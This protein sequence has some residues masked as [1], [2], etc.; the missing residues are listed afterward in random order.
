MGFVRKNTGI[1]LTGGGQEDAAREA[2]RI[3]TGKGEEAIA[4]IDEQIGPFRDFG[5]TAGNQLGGAVLGQDALQGG[6]PFGGFS[7]EPNINMDP[8][9]VLNNP[10]FKALAQ[11]QEQRL[12]NQRGALGV[13]G[14]GGTSDML[15]Q[16]I[17]SLGT[18]F[19]DR[20]INQQRQQ[21]QDQLGFEQQGFQNTFQT[22]QQ[23]FQNQLAA[24]Q[25]RFGQL[26]DQTRLGSNAATNQATS[27][28][29][30]I[31]GIGNAQSAVPIVGGNV[32]FQQGQNALKGASEFLS[33]IGG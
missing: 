11:Q 13:G 31:Q 29:N 3:Q 7:V 8:N 33:G 28:S 15:Q 22:E 5:I 26:F 6:T 19:Q 10:L 30:I 4:R 2:A 9:R 23:N 24:N 12:I 18:Q 20:D 1:D 14:S 27:G 17:L 21:F 32:K 16:N 25:T